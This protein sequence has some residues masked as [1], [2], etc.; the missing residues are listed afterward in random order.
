MKLWCLPHHFSFSSS[1]LHSFGTL[2][3]TPNSNSDQVLYSSDNMSTLFDNTDSVYVCWKLSDST[4]DSTDTPAEATASVPGRTSLFFAPGVPLPS[5]LP[6]GTRGVSV[7]GSYPRAMFKKLKECPLDTHPPDQAMY[8]ILPDT[9]ETEPCRDLLLFLS[10]LYDGDVSYDLFK[11]AP[12]KKL[13]F[14]KFRS[15]LRA[16]DHFDVPAVDGVL[17]KV[18]GINVRN[19]GLQVAIYHAG[20]LRPKDVRR[21]NMVSYLA[22][23]FAEQKQVS[24][25]PEMRYLFMIDRTL[26]AE[27]AGLMVS[28]P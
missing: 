18:Y 12:G 23:F 25:S 16:A 3:K 13:D 20:G 11:A 27:V 2:L 1:P 26:G 14:P 7:L 28:D 21:K 10:R 9:I 19:C 5:G 22:G 6:P 17:K 8:V 24:G 15:T 4:E